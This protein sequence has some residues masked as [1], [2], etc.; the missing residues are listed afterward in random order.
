VKSTIYYYK[1]QEDKSNIKSKIIT[2]SACSLS[3]CLSESV[4]FLSKCHINISRVKVFMCLIMYKDMKT[5][6][7]VKI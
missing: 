6:G 7:E 3:V 2:C 4:K 1:E 5:Y